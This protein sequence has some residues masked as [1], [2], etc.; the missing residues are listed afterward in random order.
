MLRSPRRAASLAL[1]TRVALSLISGACQPQVAPA[2]A[3]ASDVAVRTSGR[4]PGLPAVG[5]DVPESIR[6]VVGASDR[7]AADRALDEA[8]HPAELLA[9]AGAHEGTRVGEVGAWEG[10][11]SELL[12]RVVGATGHVYAEDP[13]EFDEW[14]RKAWDERGKRAVLAARITH[15]RRPFDDPFGPD[16]RGLAAVFSVMF[17]HD[18]VWL[19]VDRAKMNAAIFA[20]LAPG[21]EYVVVDHSARSGDGVAVAKTLHRIEESVLV[22]EIT[23]AGFTV[24]AR[25]DFLRH[26]ED[27]RDW[28]A[29]DEA[30]PEKRGKSDRFVL[31]FLRP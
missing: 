24:A 13:Q 3:P 29:G 6:V 26:P 8:R 19:R 20:A 1:A 22:D 18:T 2:G 16:V 17:Y 11:T 21:G 28:N 9:F 15:L 7:S 30:P 5:V 23:R 10:Y 14:I 31:R 12:S 27:T 25:A 4:A